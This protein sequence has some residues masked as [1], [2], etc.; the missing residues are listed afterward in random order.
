MERGDELEKALKLLKE[1]PAERVVLNIPKN[2]VLGGRLNNF[3]AL[4][5][6]SVGA[7]KELII[8]SIDEHILELAGLAGISALNPFFR[9]KERVVADILPKGVLPRKMEKTEKIIPEPAEKIKVHEEKPLLVRSFFEEPKL[10]PKNVSNHRFPKKFASRLVLIILI[11]GLGGF[12]VFEIAANVLPRATISL[13]LKKIPVTFSENVQISSAAVS[14]SFTDQNIILPG[15]LLVATKNIELPFTA[16]AKEKVEEKAHG[17]LT[18]YNAYSPAAQSL[19]KSTRFESPAKKIFRLDKAVTIPGAS[20]LNGK[21]TPS[22]IEVEVTA[23]ETGESYNTDVSSSPWRIPGFSGT[24]K[25]DGFYAEAVKP[26][27]GG[28]IGEKAV[29]SKGDLESARAKIN[30]SLEAALKT[31]MLIL[32]KDKFKLLDGARTFIGTKEEIKTDA[33][34][35]KF[36]IFS[37]GEMRELVFEE[38]TLKKVLSE[39]AKGSLAADLPTLK[40]FNFELHYGS[41]SEDLA[42]GKMAV[43]VNGS[44][45]YN[46]DIDNSKLLKDSVGL[47]EANLKEMIFSLPGLEKAKISLWP[48]WVKK[49]PENPERVKISAE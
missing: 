32:L 15:E 1:N 44:I 45:V 16:S 20:V 29:P 25:Y 27:T 41:S 3:Q 17:V 33:G 48:F 7:G 28:L 47:K 35:G 31:Q 19:V 6:E 46:A 42:N 24:P 2:S 30:S 4:K 12:G 34:D 11:I 43:S 13:T 26:I 22:K 21:I 38:E 40:I 23:D 39:K 37:E 36:S 8:E 49:V 18:V 14:P 9:T 5:K 10:K